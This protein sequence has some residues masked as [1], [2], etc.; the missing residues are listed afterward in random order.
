[1]AQQQT[2]RTGTSLDAASPVS[3]GLAA[4]MKADRDARQTCHKRVRGYF[5]LSPQRCRAAVPYSD[6]T[7]EGTNVGDLETKLA[8]WTGPSSATEVKKQERTERMIRDAIDA[9]APFESMKR[10][11]YAKGSYANNT[12]VRSD[13]DVDIA[14]EC[15]DAFY[16]GHQTPGA[17]PAIAAYTG[18]WTPGRLRSELVAALQ[19]KFGDAV[20]TS[21]STAI[22]I[23]SN[24]A[25][26]E[27]DVVPC[28][29][30]RYY[31]SP[32]NTRE[33]TRIFRTDGAFMENYSALQLSNGRTKNSRTNH[34]YK[35]TVRILKRLENA[36]A[37]DGHHREVPSFFV[38]CLVYNCPDDLFMLPSWGGTVKG[39]IAEIFRATEGPEPTDNGKRWV[40]VNEAKYLFG[41]H[42]KWTRADAREFAIAG[43][44]Y[45]D[46]KDV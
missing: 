7:N 24:S 6:E 12:N 21:G 4:Q 41:S 17:T 27:A 19:V 29:E 33:G 31:F 26:V 14:V 11:V 34:N 32:T 9:H 39:V 1:M 35:K 8:G 37:N 15:G 20:D 25:R 46:L 16:Y 3:V 28:F 2:R 42:Q 13:S 22:Q 23:H 44:N 38:E 5:V 30:Y 18:E 36:M 45:L 10:K 40:E 43:W